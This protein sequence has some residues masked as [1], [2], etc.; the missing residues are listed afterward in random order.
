MRSKYTFQLT[1]DAQVIQLTMFNRKDNRGILWC[2]LT[3]AAVCAYLKLQVLTVHSADTL[4][5]YRKALICTGRSSP[6]Q[7]SLLIAA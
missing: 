7:S 4:A 6:Q 5:F 1:L 3:I 2:S